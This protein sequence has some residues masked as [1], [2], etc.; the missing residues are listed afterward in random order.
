MNLGTKVSLGVS[1][2][3]IFI[4]VVSTMGFISYQTSFVEKKLLQRAEETL[5]IMEAMHTQAMLHRGVNTDTDPVIAT[6]N[7][8]LDRLSKARSNMMVWFVMGPKVLAYQDALAQNIYED[9]PPRDDIDREA[10]ESGRR[11]YRYAG[12]NMFRLTRPVVLG[13]GGGAHPK[14]ATCH[15]RK[16]GIRQGEVI[17]AYSIALSSSTEQR[18]LVETERLAIIVSV[19][20]SVVIAI[21]CSFM[22]RRLAT[23]P[24]S[25]MTAKMGEL[26]AGNLSLEIPYGNRFD[27]IG[28]MARSVRVFKEN[29]IEK[30]RVE[31]SARQHE[32]ELRRVLR[33][34]TMGEM[35]SALVHELAQPLAIIATY[36]GMLV[37]RFKRRNDAEPEFID[38]LDKINS[39]S[40]R[41]SRISKTIARHVRGTEPQREIVDLKGLLKSI[42]PLVDADARENSVRFTLEAD[43][44]DAVV[45]ANA[46]EIESVILNLAHNSVEAMKDVDRDG[47][48]LRISASIENKE[49]VIAVT[50][51]GSGMSAETRDRLF[52][53]FFTTKRDGMGMGLAICRTIVENHG[54][55]FSV[56]PPKDH[57]TTIRFTLPLAEGDDGDAR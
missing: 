38:I 29:A 23:R 56:D 47:R 42:S 18:N 49:A 31:D 36:S 11:V 51:T 30:K 2:A 28:D 7:D 57:L 37:A 8:V 13:K 53:P 22:I 5:S 44:I 33:R 6:M 32:I 27:E 9:E 50:D 35:A 40:H 25:E 3:L 12:D 54:G 14:C 20:A 15:S 10:L 46:T 55:R 41:A 4:L 21:V 34:S 24:I 17:G 26:A 39:A 16:M 1:S 43:D 45:H 48:S 52:E 19:L